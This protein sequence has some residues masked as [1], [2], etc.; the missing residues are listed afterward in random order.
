MS[1]HALVFS[2]KRNHRRI[3][4]VGMSIGGSS[5]VE[6]GQRFLAY[7]RLGKGLGGNTLQ[8][9]GGDLKALARFFPPDITINQIDRAQLMV[10]VSRLLDEPR[11]APATIKR[12]LA[13]LKAMFRW[14]EREEA[15]KSNPFRTIDM[16]VRLPK[17]LPRTLA[18]HE[19]ARLIEHVSRQLSF[20]GVAM[21][22]AILLLIA[23]GMRVGELSALRLGDID[24]QTGIIRVQGKGRRERQVFIPGGP[25]ASSLADYLALRP[26][27]SS[28]SHHL[29]IGT[30]GQTLT[31]QI[32]RLR[33]HRLARGAG[34]NRKITP[35]MLRHSAATQLIEAGVD[36]RFVQKLLGH[37]SISTTQIYTEVSDTALKDAIS[38]ADTVGRLM[39]GSPHLP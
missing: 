14:L 35:H 27:I 2:T 37:A 9:Y 18:A 25:V 21:R 31:P 17:N 28:S 33:L 23:T 39:T 12:R 26:R 24:Q 3:K 1:L 13:C 34:I 19:L 15:I 38:R 30:N 8:A 5:F 29:L 10:S 16:M 36:I 7:C 6:A 11:R 32:I 4:G 20:D 22:A